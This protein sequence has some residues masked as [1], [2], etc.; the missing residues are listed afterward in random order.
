MQIT[1]YEVVPP[2]DQGPT[3]GETTPGLQKTNENQQ[4]SLS[5]WTNV[6]QVVL[7]FDK[8]NDFKCP[9]ISEPSLNLDSGELIFPAFRQVNYVTISREM[10]C[11][12][13]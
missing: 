3:T 11:C 9:E 2:T 8:I 7:D 13:T 5:E 12:S 1:C 4:R 6:P 10:D